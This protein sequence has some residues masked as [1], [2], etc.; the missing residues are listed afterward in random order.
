[1]FTK[2]M[3]M[4]TN[5]KVLVVLAVLAVIGGGYIFMKSKKAIENVDEDVSSMIEMN[6]RANIMVEEETRELSQAPQVMPTT[7]EVI[8]MV[9]PEGPQPM[10]IGDDMFA[11]F[12]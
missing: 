5:K 9:V 2:V 1:M 3:K 6:M 4:I 7:E 12:E 8:E 11:I 10:A